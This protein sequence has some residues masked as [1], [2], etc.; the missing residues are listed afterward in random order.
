MFFLQFASVFCSATHRLLST[1]IAGSAVHECWRQ[2]LAEKQ[3]HRIGIPRW[4]TTKGNALCDALE[5][6]IR[7]AMH[8]LE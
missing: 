3:P 6:M 8:L 7:R 4:R 5:G 1:N 2:R